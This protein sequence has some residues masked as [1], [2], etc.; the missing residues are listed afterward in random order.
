MQSDHDALKVLWKQPMDQG[1]GCRIAE[2]LYQV[3][4]DGSPRK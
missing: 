1:G 2:A 4:P 3:R